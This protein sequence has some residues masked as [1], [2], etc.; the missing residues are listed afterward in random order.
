MRKKVLKWGDS[1]VIR[2]SKAE[3]ELFGI[4]EGDV[5]DLDDMLIDEVFRKSKERKRKKRWKL[6]LFMT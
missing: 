5:I 3:V 6:N 4:A 2:F 1:L